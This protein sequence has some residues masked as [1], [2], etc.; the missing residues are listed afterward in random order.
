MGSEWTRREFVWGLAAVAGVEAAYG[1]KGAFSTQPLL[2]L[3]VASDIHINRSWNQ[4]HY[5]E[6]ALR[7]FDAQGADAVL[8]PGD[9]AHLGR[10]SELES[11]ARVWDRV[12]PKN[13]GRDGRSVERMIVTGNHE[14]A[15]WPGLWDRTSEEEMARD[16]LDYADNMIRT[17]ERLF[18]EKYEPIW[19]K[20]VK[21]ITFIGR[22]W[23]GDARNVPPDIESYM[24]SAAATLP[25]NRP[26]FYCQHAHP[27]NTC[28]GTGASFDKG[29]STRALSPFANAVA[30]S[31][32]SHHS[33]VDDRSVWQGTFTSIACGCV[34]EAGYG[35]RGY[36][37]ALAPYHPSYRNQRMK[38]LPA[39][40]NE[41]RCC[42]LVEVYEDRLIVRRRSLQWD[43]LLGPDW[44]VNL[45]AVVGGDY[46]FVRQRM[47][48]GAPQ[49]PRDAKITCEIAQD[50][51]SAGPGLKGK[52]CLRLMF[53]RAESREGSRVFDYIVRV[54]VNGREEMCLKVLSYDFCLPPAHAN[55]PGECLIGLQEIP[56]GEITFVVTPRNCYG[57][58]GR[59]ISVVW[60]K[61]EPLC[62]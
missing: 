32:H 44:V 27:D 26:F 55:A 30:L 2:R 20:E 31:G 19:R 61:Q 1:S 23:Q 3:G 8:F 40:G 14:F 59:C 25:K 5:L 45:P 9:I 54:L 4:E 49:F 52:P 10:I 24:K 16:R 21:D 37:N 28:Y 17:W 7:W 22:Q 46:D 50:P 35:G 58:E 6:K 11:F 47:T 13:R 56:A 36:E 62:G 43:E 53:P 42:A 60:K 34:Q 48:R 51:D 39:F 57:T 18:G 29:A 33:L 41:G 12:F 15:F 38:C